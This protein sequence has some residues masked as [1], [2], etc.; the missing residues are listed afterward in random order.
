MS[1]TASAADASAEVATRARRS[2][3]R[4]TLRTRALQAAVLLLVI[5]LWWAVAALRLIDPLYLPGPGAVLSA[6]VDAN[7]CLVVDEASGRTVCGVQNYYLWEHLVA[8]LQRIG[9][10]VA[11]AVVAGVVLGFLMSMWEPV[12]TALAPYLNFLRA[13]PPLGYIGLIIVWVGIGDTSKYLLLF[14]AAF[15]PIVI[16]TI[17][18]VRGVREDQVLAARSMGAGPVDVA[19]YVVLPAA[20]ASILSGVRLSVGFAWTTVVAAELN[21]GIPGIGGLAYISGTQLNTPLTI[22]C[23]IV[24]GL[25]AVALDGCIRLVGDRLTPWHGKV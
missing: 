24:I 9:L 7:R 17:D 2:R 5:L 19:R 18:G 4:R 11:L 21:N 25:V 22:A 13:L 16:A 20:A 6:F 15:P 14:L 8:S 12:N 1:T 3:S 10:G 23:I